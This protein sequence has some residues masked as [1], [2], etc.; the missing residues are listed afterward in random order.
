MVLLE[1]LL[2]HGSAGGWDEVVYLVVPLAIVS[3]I[4]VLVWRGNARDARSARNK[5]EQPPAPDGDAADRSVVTAASQTS[6]REEG[7]A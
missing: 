7:E 2:L 3:L 1:L 6:R 4:G 5:P